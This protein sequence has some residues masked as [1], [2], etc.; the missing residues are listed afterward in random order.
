[1]YKVRSGYNKI[2][3]TAKALK[4]LFEETSVTSDLDIYKFWDESFLER[5]KLF[6]ASK[7]NK[8]KI[9]TY[10]DSFKQ[11]IKAPI[12]INLVRISFKKYIN[13]IY[14]KLAKKLKFSICIFSC[15]KT[16]LKS[17]KT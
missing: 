10:L 2:I 11:F 7:K 16:I 14:S 4:T 15:R 8:V 5:E 17:S 13:K 6:N 12:G 3:F 1:M 9:N